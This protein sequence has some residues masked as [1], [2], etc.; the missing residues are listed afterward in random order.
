MTENAMVQPLVP[1]KTLVFNARDV[2]ITL[3]GKPPQIEPPK[4]SRT[5][6]FR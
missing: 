2:G 5:W 4:P 3:I 1:L 6:Y